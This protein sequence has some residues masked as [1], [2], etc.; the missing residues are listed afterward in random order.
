MSERYRINRLAHLFAGMPGHR[1][2]VLRVLHQHAHTL[3]VGIR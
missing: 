3:K 2:D 1:F